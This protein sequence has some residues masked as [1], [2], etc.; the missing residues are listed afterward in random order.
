MQVKDKAR[1]DDGERQ[2]IVLTLTASAEEVDRCADEF[3]AE[4]AQRDIPGFRKGKAPRTVL[5]KI[6]GGREAAGASIGERIVNTY[7]F[8]A[9]DDSDVVFLEDPE[10]N[11][12]SVPEAGRPFTFT[13]SGA[14]APLMTLSSYEP[15]AIEM[16]PEKATD[17][18]IEDQL[19]QIQEYYHYFEDIDDPEHLAEKGD[20]MTAVLSVDNHGKVV[21][22]LSNVTRMIGLGEGIMPASFDEKV[23]GAK[24]GDFLEFD[25]EA[26]NDEGESDFGDGEL[27]A[28]VEVKSFRRRLVPAIDDELALKVGCMD[29]EDMHKQLR[30]NINAQKS[31]ELPKLMVDKAV[32]ALTTR[33]EGEVPAYYV[34]F[35]RQDVGREFMQSLEKQGTNLQQWMIENNVKGDDMKEDIVK[36]AERRAAIDCALEA[37]YVNKGLSI[38]DEDVDKMFEGD[39]EMD[40]RAAWEEA[41]RM[42]NIRKMCRQSKASQWLVDNAEVTVVEN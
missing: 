29:V 19:R 32:D 42:A 12:D 23:Y 40:T 18:E 27:H 14:V 28:T 20:Y 1:E 3:Y 34:E 5:E 10:I 15:V 35:I 17:A 7:A 33:L 37:L 26:K 22:S 36:E 16:P 8:E 13:V 11:I 21:S 24:V 38:T 39:D 30:Y 4:L 2:E 9:V 25:F 6:A 31:K 41:H